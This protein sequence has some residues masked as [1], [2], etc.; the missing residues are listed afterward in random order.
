MAGLE[1]R[2]GEGEGEARRPFADPFGVAFAADEVGEDAGVELVLGDEHALARVSAVSPG[3]SDLDLAEDVARIDFRRDE[4]DGRA[5]AALPA[6][7]TASCGLIPLWR[8][9][10]RGGC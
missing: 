4:V 1:A 5:G 10:T 3:R 8:G 9:K 6:A 7:S 2:L